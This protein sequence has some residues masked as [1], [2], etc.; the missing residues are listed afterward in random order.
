M[1]PTQQRVWIFQAVVGACGLA[2]GIY[3]GLTIYLRNAVE[4]SVWAF[5]MDYLNG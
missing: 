1:F 3:L 2:S 4:A 5:S